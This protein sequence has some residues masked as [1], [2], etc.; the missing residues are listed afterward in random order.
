M[1]SGFKNK[2]LFIVFCAI[3]GLLS[4]AGLGQNVF[5]AGAFI[6]APKRVDMAY[7][8]KRHILYITSADSVLRY[9]LISHS[10]LTPYKL[11]GDLRGIDISPDE[12]T[13]AIADHNLYGIYLINL[14]TG[15][16]ERAIYP[17]SGDAGSFSVSFASNSLL[18]VTS[19][20][21]GSGWVPLRKCNLNT[22]KF[23][24]IAEVN[25]DTILSPNAD[26]T[27]IG[28]AESNSSDGPFG[29]YRVADGNL[30]RRNGYDHGTGWFNYEIAV[31]HNGTQYAIPTFGGT[32]LADKNLTKFAIVGKY[33]GGHPV[34]A[35]YN[36]T[37]DIVYF[38]WSG[39]SNVYAYDTNTLQKIG[40]YDFKNI[41]PDTGNYA[42]VN[43]R[44]KVS[45]DGRYLFVSVK[46]GVRYL[47]LESIQ[48]NLTSPDKSVHEIR[49][50]T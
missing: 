12:N 29:R 43:G 19:S 17:S 7:D 37:K 3:S 49:K 14:K 1:R 36:P 13:L 25:Q 24:S 32:I 23:T 10:F 34:G 9:S 46:D 28:F 33:N 39:T 5:A 42:Y 2:I 47:D 45:K 35:A 40:S 31:N 30:L 6:A 16:Y 27:V 41:F 26:H 38:P 50:S 20:F 18:L 8:G 48:N 21:N 11:S 44:A 22:H 15:K 4:F